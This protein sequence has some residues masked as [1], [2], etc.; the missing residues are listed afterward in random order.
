[1]SSHRLVYLTATLVVVFV[2]VLLIIDYLLSYYK[3]ACIRV[4]GRVD[5]CLQFYHT[6]GIATLVLVSVMA[7]T[8]HFSR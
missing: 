6:V 5:R 8:Y 4:N 3:P 7:I 2:V 1:M